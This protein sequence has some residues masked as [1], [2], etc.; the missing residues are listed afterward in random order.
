[1]RFLM[2]I[3]KIVCLHYYS[4]FV[5]NFFFK[6]LNIRSFMMIKKKTL[7][8]LRNLIYYYISIKSSHIVIKW[9]LLN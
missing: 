2:F 8:N 1:M 4:N 3:I 9:T 5:V 7:L 6:I